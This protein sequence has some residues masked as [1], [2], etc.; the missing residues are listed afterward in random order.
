MVKQR[1]VGQFTTDIAGNNVTAEMENAFRLM[2][3]ARPWNFTLNVSG[4][5]ASKTAKRISPAVSESGIFSGE[6]CFWQS[7]ARSSIDVLA[8]CHLHTAIMTA[9]AHM[10]CTRASQACATW[11]LAF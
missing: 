6:L 11:P 2:N 9:P 8:P 5:T 3:I 1:L 4:F 10:D 7:I